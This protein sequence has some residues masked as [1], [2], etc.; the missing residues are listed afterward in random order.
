M[1]VIYKE[2]RQIMPDVLLTVTCSIM[3]QQEGKLLLV[4]EADPEIYGLWNQPAGHVEP[5]ETF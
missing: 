1:K 3:I 4:Q 5:G 2:A